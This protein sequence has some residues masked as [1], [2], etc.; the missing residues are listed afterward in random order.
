MFTILEQLRDKLT[1]WCLSA[2]NIT[3]GELYYNNSPIANDRY[4]GDS[5]KFIGE[6]DLHNCYVKTDIGY[7]KIKKALKT[8]PY[9]KWIITTKNHT[10][11]CADEHIIILSDYTECYIRD[12]VIGQTVLT[13]TG[14]ESIL[15]IE[16]T[17]NEENMFDLELDDGRY[18]Y[19]TNGIL[20]HN[21]ATSAAYL[22]WYAAFNSEKTILIA[23]N[24]NSNAMEMIVR[25]KFMLENTPNW[26]KPGVRDDG[27]NKHEIGFDNGSRIIST[28]TSESAGR[29]LSISCI[30]GDSMITVLNKHT[31]KIQHIS[32]ENFSNFIIKEDISSTQTIITTNDWKILTPTGF[33]SFDGI[34]ITHNKKTLQITTTNDS[35]QCTLDHVFKT[36]D[37]DWIVANDL[38]IGVEL[39]N[40]QKV[41]QIIPIEENITVYDPINVENGNEYIANNLVHH[42]CLFLDEFAFVRHNVQ[43]EFWAS[44]SPTLATGGRLI[45]TSTP[46][47]DSDLFSKMW[48]GANI[49][50][51]YNS[52]LGSNHFYPIQ[53][54]WDAPPGRD[55]AFKKAEIAK[56][57]MTKF[58]QE[59]LCEFI[60]SDPLLFDTMV[61]SHL[62]TQINQV[63]PYGTVNDI[64]FYSPPKPNSTVLIAM[65]PSTGT[66]SDFSTILVFEYP[67]LVQAA[68]WRNNTM[69]PSRSYQLLKK[70][71]SIYE[72][73]NVHCYFSVE[74]NGVGE[75]IITAFELDDTPSRTCEFISEDGNKRVGMTTTGKSKM[76]ACISAKDLVEKGLLTIKSKIL[77]QEMKQY[78]RKAHSY[79]AK[80][81]CTDDMVSALLIITRML[82]EISSYDQV[83]F[84]KLYAGAYDDLGK[85]DKYDDDYRGDSIVF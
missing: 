8:I 1:D 61:L 10:L 75:G 67:S 41:I 70:L 83:A 18:L 28:A 46:N 30:S 9:R 82:K 31:N 11:E 69:S 49:P 2:S 37:G 20:S 81:G 52:K 19:Y 44:M 23:S 26:L 34:V 36:S 45:V 80:Q 56:I 24:K 63:K 71:I 4:N 29:G 14:F 13:D 32:I 78:V 65:D 39:A 84:D 51:S 50:L 40:N 54:D 6:S 48:R 60:S 77:I 38:C 43:E 68:E 5:L 21:S 42:N 59:Y 12:L 66:G 16:I 64:I 15:N 62:T 55:E 85:E 27:Y 72:K 53:I 47:G 35:I 74:N 7:S 57:G 22:Y 58:R 33:Q 73:Q 17:N 76:I 25:V 3:I 79:A